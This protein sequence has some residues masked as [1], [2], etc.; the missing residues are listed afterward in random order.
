MNVKVQSAGSGIGNKPPVADA[1]KDRQIQVGETLTLDRTDSTDEDG[2]IVSYK[3]NIEEWDDEDPTGKLSST[4]SGKPKF[5]TPSLKVSPGIYGIDLTVEDNYGAID[6]DTI[7]L[8]VNAK[9]ITTS[10]SQTEKVS[11][12]GEEDGPALF[13]KSE[14]KLPSFVERTFQLKP[15]ILTCSY[16]SQTNG[17]IFCNIECC[18][19]PNNNITTFAQPNTTLVNQEILLDQLLNHSLVF[20]NETNIVGKIVP[21]NRTESVISPNATSLLLPFLMRNS[22]NVANNLSAP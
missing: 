20:L 6:T 1:G 14:S 13:N 19:Q 5:S 8:R 11:T 15:F 21:L 12:A 10:S 9:C 17:L 18:L 2:T 16:D 4:N 7:L 22:S 3:W